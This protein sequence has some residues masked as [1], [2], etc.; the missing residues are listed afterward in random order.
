MIR[1]EARSLSR[2][3]GQGPLAVK[4]LDRVSIAVQAG[5]VVGLL[6]PSGS[7][8]ST[9]LTCMGLLDVAEEGEVRIDDQIVAKNG[10]FHGD[11]ATLRRQRIGFVFQRANLVPFLDVLENVLL[12]LRLEGS[13][14]R[15]DRSRVE[16]LLA[17][18]DLGDRLRHTPEALS[19][20][21]RQRVALARALVAR[22]S[23]VLADEPTAALDAKRGR[24]AILALRETSREAGA[25]VVVV[26]HDSRILDAFDR[27]IEL[28]D[29]KLLE[30]PPG[31]TALGST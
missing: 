28:E 27:T 11:P 21:Q 1:I 17:R 20:G 6:G 22:P 12:P 25:A 29:G 7:G 30:P 2:T 13:V 24:E 16:T 4:A 19:G 14:S 3:Y 26:T 18:L 9:L 31:H 8:K 10:K 15:Q 23:V 5:E